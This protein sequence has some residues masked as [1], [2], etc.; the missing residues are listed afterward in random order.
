MSSFWCWCRTLLSPRGAKPPRAR[1][2]CRSLFVVLPII[3]CEGQHPRESRKRGEAESPVFDIS[4][5]GVIVGF[6]SEAMLSPFGAL[7]RNAKMP[8]VVRKYTEVEVLLAHGQRPMCRI[9]TRMPSS[10]T[11]RPWPVLSLSFGRVN[12][13]YPMLQHEPAQPC[14]SAQTSVPI[15]PPAHPLPRTRDE[16]PRTYVLFAS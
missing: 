11:Q 7:S 15:Y 2:T 10:Y 8:R 4:K 3:P 6:F 9:K 14:S 16:I 5:E 13:P 12:R 1:T